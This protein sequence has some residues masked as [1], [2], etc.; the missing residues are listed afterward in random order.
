[1]KA[2]L[3]YPIL[4]ALCLLS[5]CKSFP[6]T[7]ELAN[8]DSARAVYAG[9]KLAAVLA[10][11]DGYRV[12]VG[13]WKDAAFRSEMEERGLVPAGADMDA[14]EAFFLH[15]DG[16]EVLVC[17]S[18]ESGELYGCLELCSRLE[19]KG[20]LPRHL[21]LFDRPEMVMR[22][23]CIG[24]QKTYYLPGRTVYEYP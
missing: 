19:G 2:R 20:G 23:T 12:R 4:M 8:P 13:C 10:A 5:S 24:I 14:K 17:G 11:H 7:V 6:S 16:N 22:G 21:S 1:M 15:A 18:D 3:L 9:E